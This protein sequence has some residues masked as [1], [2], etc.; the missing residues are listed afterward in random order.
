MDARFRYLIGAMGIAALVFACST[1]GPQSQQQMKEIY[2][3]CNRNEP[4]SC[5]DYS[6][7]VQKD[8]KSVV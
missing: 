6:A 7:L 3:R 4:A 5:I 2:S 8:R 1:A